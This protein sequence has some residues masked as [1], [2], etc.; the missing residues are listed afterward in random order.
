MK[1]GYSNSALIWKSDLLHKQQQ[2]NYFTADTAVSTVTSNEED[3]L[4]S[5]SSEQLHI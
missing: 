2:V 5:S 4:Q 1:D 3:H